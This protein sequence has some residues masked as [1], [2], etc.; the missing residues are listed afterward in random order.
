MVGKN[1]SQF[2]PQNILDNLVITEQ[3]EESVQFTTNQT[4]IIGNFIAKKGYDDNDEWCFIFE[5]SSKIMELEGEI[6]RHIKKSIFSA[7][8]TFD[9][10]VGNTPEI[11]N[12]IEKAKIFSRND[13]TV[14]IYGETGTGKEVFAQSIHNASDRAS[15][16]FVAIN[17]GAIPDTLI[18]S[19]L[20]GYETGSFTGASSK[21]KVGLIELAHRGTVFLDDIDSISLGF[22]SKILRVIQ[23]REILRIGAQKPHSID[24]RFIV[25][26][27]K[28]L[29]KLVQDKQFRSDLY[30]RL[31]VLTLALPPLIKRKADIEL[32]LRF[33]L[34]QFNRQFYSSIEDKFCNIFFCGLSY[35]FPG[36]VRELIAIVERFT[37][38]VDPSRHKDTEYLCKL[39]AD[40]IFPDIYTTQE[41]SGQFEFSGDYQ[42]DL[43]AAQKRIIEKYISNFGGSISET[44]K[45]M[46]ISRASLYQKI[47]ELDILY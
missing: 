3:S 13:A 16:P 5:N 40:C 20:F 35:N 39:V 9:D 2:I 17:C 38:L 4:R 15:Y 19:E 23:E 1:L 24:V 45:K 18:E 27:N 30:Y 10:I 46:G 37:T 44:A 28:S 26:T 36:N 14:M 11:K 31:N 33:Y 47:R 34:Q 8:Y 32:L 12:T 7:K 22:Q 25:A 41:L 29:L 21:G 6:R 43:R 42:Q